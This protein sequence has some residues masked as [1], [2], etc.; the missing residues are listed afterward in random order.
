M[1]EQSVITRY[2]SW[3][4]IIDRNFMMDD[5][6]QCWSTRAPVKVVGS[7]EYNPYAR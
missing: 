1:G 5:L 6:L 7:V 2:G 3:D 4:G